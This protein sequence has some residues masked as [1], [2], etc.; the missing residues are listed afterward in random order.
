M[1]STKILNKMDVDELRNYINKQDITLEYYNEVVHAQGAEVTFLQAVIDRQEER[2]K[3]ILSLNS[4]KAVMTD[5]EYELIKKY[6]DSKE[7]R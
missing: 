6:S 2:F 7:V 3:S 4:A 5:I 1:L